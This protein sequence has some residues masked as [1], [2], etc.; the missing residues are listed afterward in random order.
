M[1]FFFSSFIKLA[2]AFQ[3]S[4]PS[5]PIRQRCA[6]IRSLLPH[7]PAG[8]A[9]SVHVSPLGSLHNRTRGN[10]G[11]RYSYKGRLLHNAGSAVT[12]SSVSG[13]LKSSSLRQ[14]A[15]LRCKAQNYGSSD[16]A[17]T[18]SAACFITAEQRV[19][20]QSSR[21]GVCERSPPIFSSRCF[22]KTTTKQTAFCIC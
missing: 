18:S 16:A 11:E 21:C 8:L 13:R 22:K 1:Q 3:S 12:Q 15:L 2:L 6:W 20:W 5:F 10:L 14:A 9:N 4:E 17:Y 19:A 7:M